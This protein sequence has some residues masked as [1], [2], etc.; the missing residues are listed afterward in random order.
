MAYCTSTD[1]KLYLGIDS[2]NTGDDTLI[3]A[4]VARAQAYIE[5]YTHRLF[6]STAD[7]TRRFTV[8]QDNEGRTLYFDEDICSL[9]TVITNADASTGT[10]I[11]STQYITLPRNET[12]YYG[13]RIKDSV[14]A[15][16]TYTTDAEMGITVA[17][18]WA[19]STTPPADIKHACIRLSAFYYRL[20]DSQV[21]DVQS[22]PAAGVITVPQGV[23]KDVD[24]ALMSY[25][26]RL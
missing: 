2:T 26:K 19:Y 7:S 9:T 20:K 3:T 1:V 24:L 18:K 6:S 13:I 12:P 14:D 4:L 10:T 21:F 23:P 17:G 25:V 5:T 22:I 16:W 15:D 8:D 11:T